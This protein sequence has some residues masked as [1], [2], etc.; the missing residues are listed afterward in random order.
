MNDDTNYSNTNYSYAS[1]EERD[2][3]AFLEAS[4]EETPDLHDAQVETEKGSLLSI[5]RG[6]LSVLE[7]IQKTAEKDEAHET[8][9]A[10][11]FLIVAEEYEPVVFQE[12]NNFSKNYESQLYAAKQLL[13]N[14]TEGTIW[15]SLNELYNYYVIDSNPVDATKLSH[16]LW[17]ATIYSNI[18]H[19]LI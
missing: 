15:N 9:F 1:D 6:S 18:I 16:Q 13:F 17:Y 8:F 10:R 14:R 19:K 7:L 5:A 3:F 4:L 11:K 12:L 2:F